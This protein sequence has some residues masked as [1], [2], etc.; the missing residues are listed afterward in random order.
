MPMG[1]SIPFESSNDY[2]NR[3]DQTL[4]DH[5]P[6]G[7]G[8]LMSLCLLL[9]KRIEKGQAKRSVVGAMIR[10]KHSNQS[11]VRCLVTESDHRV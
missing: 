2:D 3:M 9:K 11:V 6:E 10:V 8:V 4:F 5:H 7:V 1:T